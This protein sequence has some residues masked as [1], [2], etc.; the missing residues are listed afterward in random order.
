MSYVKHK[1]L[2]EM[3][4][5]G[6]TFW[7]KSGEIAALL[8]IFTKCCENPWEAPEAVSHASSIDSRS[9]LLCLHNLS[10][11]QSAKAFSAME[12]SHMVTFLP[13]LADTFNN[14]MCVP[15]YILL[16]KTVILPNIWIV[17]LAWQPVF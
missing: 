16:L 1:T 12:F 9:T 15:V 4:H 5:K 6:T 3:P 10:P 14:T 11:M 2:K 13:R 7:L 17:W 8:I